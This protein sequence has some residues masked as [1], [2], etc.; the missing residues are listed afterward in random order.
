MAFKSIG[1]K[2]GFVSAGDVY[3]QRIAE[4]DQR[5]EAERQKAENAEAEK[6]NTA[7]KLVRD[8]VISVENAMAYFGYSK[9][10]ILAE[11]Q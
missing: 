6:L 3:R 8:G 7:K 5:A 4:A 11:R 1:Q 10:Q 2:Y 9:E